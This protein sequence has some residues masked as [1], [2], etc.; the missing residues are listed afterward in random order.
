MSLPEISARGRWRQEVQK[1]KVIPSYIGGWR[2]ESQK[3]KVICPQ[4]HREMETGG[5]EVKGHPQLRGRW[6]QEGQKL[7]VIHSSV[8]DGGLSQKG[9]GEWEAL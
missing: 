2:Q 9:E 3:L 6:R 4:L 1:L 7:K 8:E 5:S